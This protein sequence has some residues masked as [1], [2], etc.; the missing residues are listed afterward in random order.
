MAGKLRLLNQAESFSR[1]RNPLD[2]AKA[3]FQRGFS[4]EGLQG[5]VVYKQNRWH[6]CIPHIPYSPMFDR[7]MG[8]LICR[9]LLG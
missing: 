8:Y 1:V 3:L 4:D 7:T 6:L 5:V 2:I 9:L